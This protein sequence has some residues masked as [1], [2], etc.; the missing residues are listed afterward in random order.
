MASDNV[1]VD[2]KY[3]VQQE[4]EKSRNKSFA[5]TGSIFALIGLLVSL[6]V[7][8]LIKSHIDDTVKGGA[9]SELEKTA[10]L[11]VEKIQ[12]LE[13][14]ANGSYKSVID[15]EVHLVELQEKYS[16]KIIDL[17]NK[18]RSLENSSV[19]YGDS[20]H[21]KAS[22]NSQ[23]IRHYNANV[24]IGGKRNVHYEK[25]RTWVLEKK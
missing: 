8:Q 25:D 11:H 7:Y 18:I 14:Q 10:K 13:K 20:V 5:V 21:F 17:Q 9:L 24:I 12:L 2:I 6:G 16:A 1:S 23:Y 4:L 22:N 3:Y 15:M 19:S